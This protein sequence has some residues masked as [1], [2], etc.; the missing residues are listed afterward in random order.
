MTLPTSK[1]FPT[2][3]DKED[4]VTREYI[5]ELIYELQDQY[6]ELSEGING[7]IKSSY[8]QQREYWTPVLKGTTVPG[9]PTYTRQVGWVLRHGIIVDVWADV[10]WTANGGAAGTLYIELPY[11]VA[12]TDGFPFIG[13]AQPAG[14]AFNAGYTA[15]GV[16]A[17]TNSYRLELWQYGSG[18][19]TIPIPFPAFGQLIC[20][21]RYIGVQD[22]Q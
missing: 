4:P 3:K 20:H 14:L 12:N 7:S 19:A 11:K 13:H 17:I 10:I 9:S 1:S 16:A 8:Q 2:R 22:E 21:V 6:D 15:A 18:V 5:L